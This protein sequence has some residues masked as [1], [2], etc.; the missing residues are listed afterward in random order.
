[1][2]I[3]FGSISLIQNHVLG[4]LRFYAALW[5]ETKIFLKNLILIIKKKPEI[6]IPLVINKEY[7]NDSTKG[8]IQ[9]ECETSTAVLYNHWSLPHQTCQGAF[10]MALYQIFLYQ[11]H[12][13]YRRS[14]R[15][16]LRLRG[17]L[18]IG[19]CSNWFP[20]HSSM[21]NTIH[22]HQTKAFYCNIESKL[23]WFSSLLTRRGS[24][25]SAFCDD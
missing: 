5:K 6:Y 22:K 4:S 11:T 20:A 18:R 16:W 8:H 10:N 3:D 17:S 15:T 9:D 12:F 25:P 23:I 21:H 13:G 14:T 7:P 19:F 2:G 24:I 1:M